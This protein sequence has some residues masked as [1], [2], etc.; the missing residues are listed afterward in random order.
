VSN[1]QSISSS[2]DEQKKALLLIRAH[3]LCM[4]FTTNR[5]KHQKIVQ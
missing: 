2:A 5:K 1:G 4:V 3:L